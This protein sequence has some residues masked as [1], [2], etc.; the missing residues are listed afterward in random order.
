MVQ[1]CGDN[2]GI[3]EENESDDEDENESEDENENEDAEE[4]EIDDELGTNVGTVSDDG[5]DED[6]DEDE[7]E[8]EIVESGG[9]ITCLNFKDSA[10]DVQSF[11]KILRGTKALQKFGY[12]FNHHT[13]VRAYITWEPAAILRSLLF[14]AGHSLVGLDLTGPKGSWNVCVG[15]SPYLTNSPRHFQVLKWLY[16]QDDI[17]FEE[18]E[19]LEHPL[20]A[21][22]PW[23][24]ARRTTGRNYRMVDILPASLEELTLFPSFDH[25]DHLRMAFE[26]FPELKGTRL[27]RLKSIT[28]VG[29]LQLDQIVKRAC[30]KVGTRVV[31]SSYEG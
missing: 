5:E 31:E 30:K 15:D 29:G 26:G 21:H 6:K 14:Y 4:S 17:F 10:I 18:K 12:N 16:V 24:A 23:G 2:W 28:L 25:R 27:P 9:G 20:S 11:N 7:Y 13:S 22:N 19:V 1:G 8:Y 3:E